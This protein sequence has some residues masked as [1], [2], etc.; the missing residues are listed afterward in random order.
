LNSFISLMQWGKT[1]E[2]ASNALLS[3][4]PAFP[5]DHRHSVAS[6][7]S[8]EA[9]RELSPGRKLWH[10]LFHVS[11]KR[12]LISLFVRPQPPPPQEMSRLPRAEMLKQ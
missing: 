4:Y 1:L 6:P 2:D 12:G 8:S 11:G 9:S 10:D 3:T 5:R 7:S